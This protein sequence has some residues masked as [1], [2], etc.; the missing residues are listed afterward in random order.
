M[1]FIKFNQLEIERLF[2]QNAFIE[3]T[4][5]F[6]KNLVICVILY[7]YTT[8]NVLFKYKMTTTSLK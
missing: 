1:H 6:A 7:T 2:L 8:N 4:L 3:K 5:I